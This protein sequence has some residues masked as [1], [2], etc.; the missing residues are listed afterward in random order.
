MCI[1]TIIVRNIA[2]YSDIDLDGHEISCFGR[3]PRKLFFPRENMNIFA[4]QT[5]DIS[6]IPV[7]I[8]SIPVDI[9]YIRWSNWMISSKF[10][11]AL[12]LPQSLVTRLGVCVQNKL[13]ANFTALHA[14]YYDDLLLTTAYSA[15]VEHFFLGHQLPNMKMMLLLLSPLFLIELLDFPCRSVNITLFL[16]GCL[17]ALNYKSKLD[18]ISHLCNIPVR[19]A[20]LY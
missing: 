1:W 7:D 15:C 10:D 13:N 11:G 18:H 6:S 19:T 5:H 20:C 4:T 14:F 8:S 2:Y 9:C 3:L 12:W 16:T 17:C